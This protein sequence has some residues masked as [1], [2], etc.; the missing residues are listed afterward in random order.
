MK[1]IEIEILDYPLFIL[2][3]FT[4]C[5]LIFVLVYIYI[6]WMLKKRKEAFT[7]PET[8]LCAAFCGTGKSY[9]CNNFPEQY[10]EI[11]CWDYQGGKH[12]DFPDNCISAILS[13]IGKVKYVMISTNPAVLKR[14]AELGHS[15]NLY[16]PEN[17]LKYEYFKRYADRESHPEFMS[18]LDQYWDGWLNE[19][20]DHEGYNHTVLKSGQY[21][22]DVIK[23][24]LNH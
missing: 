16:Y 22:Q 3:C 8:I 15:V 7:K 5:G 23:P 20:K 12:V 6:Q 11:E 21:L 18:T 1:E 2:I 4:I 13:M 24:V 14:L 19:L 10:A 17:R 9:L